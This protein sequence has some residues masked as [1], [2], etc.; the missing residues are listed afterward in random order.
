MDQYIYDAEAIEYFDNKIRKLHDTYVKELIMVAAEPIGMALDE[1]S[2][3]RLGHTME[4]CSKVVGGF[5][6]IKPFA[7][8]SIVPGGDV[9]FWAELIF[10][11]IINGDVD[12]M[13][14][15]QNVYNYPEIGYCLS[16][17]WDLD[18]TSKEQINNL[19]SE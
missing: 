6:N 18:K 3:S 15:I 12:G 14:M 10:T 19:W 1:V 4:F 17:V 16:Q 5:Q 2:M 13:Y 9:E 8:A 7:R 11:Y